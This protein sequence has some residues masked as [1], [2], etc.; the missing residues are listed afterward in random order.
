M[1]QHAQPE[2]SWAD[3]LNKTGT[4]CFC[5]PSFLWTVSKL[6][7]LSRNFH[8]V[9]FFWNSCIVLNIS[10]SLKVGIE[11]LAPFFLSVKQSEIQPEYMKWK[12]HTTD[13]NPFRE[14]SLR[15]MK[16]CVEYSIIS[17]APWECTPAQKQAVVTP[18]HRRVT[19]VTQ[20]TRWKQLKAKM[21]SFYES[22]EYKQWS[23]AKHK[24]TKEVVKEPWANGARQNKEIKGSE[25]EIHLK[26]TNWLKRKLEK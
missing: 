26:F 22:D 16:L 4:Q 7:Q 15:D 20:T 19:A 21:L 18:A 5:W 24:V 11:K 1:C 13:A 14:S 17:A 23:Q 10:C 8:N 25:L 12:W 2:E 3:V 6:S 9:V